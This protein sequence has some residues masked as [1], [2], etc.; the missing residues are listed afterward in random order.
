VKDILHAQIA[1]CRQ[2]LDDLDGQLTQHTKAH[3]QPAGAWTVAM[4]RFIATVHKAGRVGY[5]PEPPP[6]PAPK[7]PKPAQA[8]PPP[9]QKVNQGPPSNPNIVVLP[10]PG[11][12]PA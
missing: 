11:T 2:L 10:T 4:A 7:K 8:P 3:I 12:A 6:P 1:Q 5:T 9:T